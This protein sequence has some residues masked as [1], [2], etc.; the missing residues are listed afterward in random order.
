CEPPGAG[1]AQPGAAERMLVALVLH[2]QGPAGAVPGRRAPLLVLGAEEVGQ[3]VGVAPAGAGV[4]VAPAVVVERV[5]ADVDHAVDGR[6]APER[7]PARPGDHP[8]GG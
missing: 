7:T 5:A 3:Q 8:L 6:A 1:G 2:P 4:G